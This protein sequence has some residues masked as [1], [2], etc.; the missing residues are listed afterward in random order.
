MP[1]LRPKRRATAAEAAILVGLLCLALASCTVDRVWVDHDDAYTFPR[2]GTYA[3][4]DRPSAG[5]DLTAGRIESEVDGALQARGFQRVDDGSADLLITGL[6]DSRSEIR[7]SSSGATVGVSRRTSRG[8]FGVMTS[9]TTRVYEVGIRILIVE[10]SDAETEMVVWRA[11][12]EDSETNDPERSA[13]GIETAVTKA[14]E[15]FPPRVGE[16]DGP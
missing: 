1:D 4:V 12:A 7:T 10:I 11:V 16:G 3:W 8:R 13:R 5:D 6:V 14:L 9:P 2:A 15:D